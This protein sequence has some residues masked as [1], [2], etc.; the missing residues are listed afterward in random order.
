LERQKFGRIGFRSKCDFIDDDFLAA[1]EVVQKY[2]TEEFPYQMVRYI[3]GE[4]IYGTRTNNQ[5]DKAVIKILLSRLLGAGAELSFAI[6]LLSIPRLNDFKEIR[7][8]IEKLADK[9]SPT[10][11]GLHKACEVRSVSR[12]FV[13]LM[14]ELNRSVLSR[15]FSDS[16]LRE[17]LF[18]SVTSYLAKLPEVIKGRDPDMTSPIDVVLANEVQVLQETVEYV[19]KDLTELSR[20]LR[21]GIQLTAE[22]RE[23]AKTLY[24][25]EV[26]SS[27]KKYKSTLRRSD[28][29]E[30]L[31]R[32]VDCFNNWMRR[33]TPL[34]VN[35]GLFANPVS[36]LMTVLHG[37]LRAKDE[38]VGE[39]HT[40]VLNREPTAQPEVGVYVQ[41]LWLEGARW[42]ADAKVLAEVEDAKII[43]LAPILHLMPVPT[44]TQVGPSF[45]QCPVFQLLH[46]DREV[47]EKKPF[48]KTIATFPLPSGKP[49]DFWALRGVALLLT[50]D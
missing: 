40:E 28:W 20:A 1:V 33:G 14:S 11:F 3:I 47:S 36:F 2:E 30:D 6:S 27:W 10:I 26:P 21:G 16:N 35:I 41:G 4:L 42:D 39:F 32:R 29:F 44:S 24:C 37:H 46:S 18:N 12:Q 25:D 34:M 13:S 9:D 5:H 8:F 43:E 23:T 7:K 19:K 50:P 45:Y 17:R 38:L 31:Q 49:D 15:H 22:L 48:V